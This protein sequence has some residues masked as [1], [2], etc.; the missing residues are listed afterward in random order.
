MLTKM[1]GNKFTA[2]VVC[3]NDYDVPPLWRLDKKSHAT[4]T[5]NWAEEGE[6]ARR[7]CLLAKNTSV[8]KDYPPYAMFQTLV[9]FLNKQLSI[10]EPVQAN[11]K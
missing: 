9:H 7:G 8:P 2:Y 10:G 6:L 3:P 5:Y 4:L 1:F 11:S